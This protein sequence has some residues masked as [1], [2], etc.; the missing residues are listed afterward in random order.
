MPSEEEMR[1]F[2]KLGRRLHIFDTVLVNRKK[3]EK[4]IEKDTFYLNVSAV[5]TLAYFVEWLHLRDNIE[6]KDSFTVEME[7]MSNES[8]RDYIRD[9]ALDYYEILVESDNSSFGRSMVKA[10]RESIQEEKNECKERSIWAYDWPVLTKS[11]SNWLKYVI[12][13]ASTIRQVI[14]LNIAQ[15]NYVLNCD[16]NNIHHTASNIFH[17]KFDKI[18]GTR[19]IVY[20]HGFGSSSLGSTVTSLQELLPEFTVIAKDIDVDPQE[21]LL[22]LI[23]LCDLEQPELVVGTSMG[24][25]YAQQ[26]RG[27]KRICINPAFNLSQHKDILREGTFEFF[28]QRCDGE[29]TFTITP[30]IS[31]HFAEMEAHQFDGIKD[32]DKEH[33]YGLFA[34][35]DTTVNCE[36]IFRQHFKNVIHFHGEHRLNRE[37]IE[38]VLVPLIRKMV[39]K[40]S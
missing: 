38:E 15:V 5:K 27:F 21:A 28:N 8:L 22:E 39:K 32:D 25:M 16:A 6:E 1:L 18:V 3:T 17:A 10:N 34:D 35:N 4:L 26:M 20:F 11:Q 19:K 9:K 37:V 2:L 40:D 36:D 13:D 14:R 30:E 31:Q 29:K 23:D 12:D 33:V 24:G 7:T